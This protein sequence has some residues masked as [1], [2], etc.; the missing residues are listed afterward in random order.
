V[1]YPGD[2]DKLPEFDKQL[3]GNRINEP[4]A[5]L[6]QGYKQEHEARRY[7]GFV[8]I[9]ESEV[10]TFTLTSDDGSQL[11]ID[12]QLVVDDDGLHTA[13]ARSGT[14]VLEAGPHAIELRWFNKSGAAELGLSWNT[15]GKPAQSVPDSAFTH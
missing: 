14:A 4:G 10:W 3:A 7:R 12:E 11:W 6:P 5:H 1:L 8:D 2:F 13:R 15:P 9:P